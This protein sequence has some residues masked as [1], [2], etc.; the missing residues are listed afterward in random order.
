V[1][2]TPEA[3]DRVRAIFSLP[4]EVGGMPF[5]VIANGERIYGGAFWTPLSS[6][7]YNG[8]IILQP[9]EPDA[10]EIVLELGYPAREAFTGPDPRGDARVMQAL[11]RAGKLK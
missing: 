6:L 9:F 1:T 8:V 5:V 10:N 11:E 4:V 7:S 2:L 3:Y